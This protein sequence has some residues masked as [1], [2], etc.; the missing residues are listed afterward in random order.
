MGDFAKPCH[1][2]MHFKNASNKNIGQIIETVTLDGPSQMAADVMMLEELTENVNLSLAVR[3][4]KWKGSWLSIG[5]NQKLLPDHW[6]DLVKKKEFF[7][8][9]LIL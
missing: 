4:Y 6:I 5:K 7:E 8:F 9:Q 3:F 1:G 2:L